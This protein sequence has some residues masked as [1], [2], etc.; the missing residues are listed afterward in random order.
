MVS[1]EFDDHW[2][3]YVALADGTVVDSCV[4]GS[5]SDCFFGGDSWH[6][7]D[8][9]GTVS[10]LGY[11][12]LQGVTTTGMTVGVYC[13]TPN[14]NGL[15]DNG[16]S[17]TSADAAIYSAFFTIAD[18]S[19]PTVHAPSGDGWTTTDWA[20]GT[21]PLAASSNDNTGIS[22]TRVYA[23]GS[24]IAT[25][26]R[27]CHYDRPVPCS[28]EPTGAVGLP[29]A[30]L[31]DGPHTIR[32]GAVDAAGNEWTEPRP[33]PLLVDNRAPAAPNGLASPAPTLSVNR[34][35]ASWSLPADL[36]TPIVGARYQLC[37][38][39][40]CEAAADAP[41]LTA[42]DGLALPGAGEA[43]LRVW[44]VDQRGHADPAGGATLTLAY[45]P[46]PAALE[47]SPAPITPPGGGPGAALTPRPPLTPGKIAADLRLSST[48]RVG[49]RVTVSGRLTRRAS[50][51][52]TVRYG[53]RIAGRTRAT[54]RR[55]SVRKG[56]FSLTFT[57]PKA[58]AHTRIGSIVVTYGGD[59]HTRSATRRATLR[60]AR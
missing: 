30:G 49:R 24:L 47:P 46:P 32:V 25:L 2:I 34:F 15:C 11:R 33:Q 17:I 57:L 1:K 52:V 45:Q 5:G 12:D 14:P 56:R 37:Q 28:D 23:D 60:L 40:S 48:R 10:N 44:L 55:A 36:G 31:A 27:T 16:F 4:I 18:P 26:Q 13:T 3:P 41:S 59:A 9:Y 42:V 39:G 51:R 22:A 21:L 54:Q 7:N 35:S 43:T 20:E 8:Q 53:A 19:P 29:T 50:G 38:A 6:P 58:F